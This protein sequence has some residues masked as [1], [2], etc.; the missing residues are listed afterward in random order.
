MK[1]RNPAATNA[2]LYVGY[3]PGTQTWTFNQYFNGKWTYTYIEVQSSAPVTGLVAT[4]ITGER[5]AACARSAVE[6]AD[7]HHGPY[8]GQQ[9]EPPRFP[10]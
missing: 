2:E 1:P 8:R 6:P 7:T 5:Q 9:F 3:D 10:A 4:G